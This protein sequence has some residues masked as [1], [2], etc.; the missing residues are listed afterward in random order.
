VR[1]V[2]WSAS[3]PNG[4]RLSFRLEC[5]A[6]GEAAWRPA[7]APGQTGGELT[8]NVGSW[9]TS[10]LPD[11]RYE[12][13][14]V[15]S[16]APDNPRR[17]RAETTRA[18]GPL[19]VDNTPPQVTVLE[20]GARDDGRALVVR[21]RAGD[22]TSPLAAA[23]L[24]LPDGATERL[25]PE[26]GVCD[27]AAETFVAV[28]ERRLAAGPEGATPIRLRV[29]VRDLAGNTGAAEAVVP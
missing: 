6:E 20:T 22:A 23:R 21:L 28:V 10:D 24:V 26:D 17:E 4:D 12:L 7:A 5:R 13:R 16:D 15:A 8:G 25:D 14:L 2:T 11:G 1:V 29:E 19:L 27:S 9:D 3:D 18:L